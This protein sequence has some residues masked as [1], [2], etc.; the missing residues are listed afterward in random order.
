[1]IKIRRKRRRNINI[2]TKSTLQNMRSKLHSLKYIVLYV[3]LQQLN[4]F[5]ENTRNTNEE[6]VAKTIKIKMNVEAMKFHQHLNQFR[7]RNH[8][9]RRLLMVTR[10][11]SSIST[12]TV[13]NLK[14]KSRTEIRILK[15]MSKC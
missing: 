1:M 12:S 7:Q 9:L 4:L 15:L 8:F 10:R 2:N 3:F 6:K 11:K 5:T 14:S 13:Q